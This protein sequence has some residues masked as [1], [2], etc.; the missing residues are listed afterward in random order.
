MKLAYQ[1]VYVL[2][3][4]GTISI[5]C[6]QD[7]GAPAPPAAPTEKAAHAGISILIPT[8]VPLHFGAPSR[9]PTNFTHT[10]EE[11]TA[12]WGQLTKMWSTPGALPFDP[13]VFANKRTTPLVCS[14]GTTAFPALLH[15]FPNRF[16][17][18]PY[19]IRIE[20]DRGQKQIDYYAKRMK[21]VH[22]L[23][24]ELSTLDLKVMDDSD[25]KS[26]VDRES[27]LLLDL[28]PLVERPAKELEQ[29]VAEAIKANEN[30]DR[31]TM[32]DEGESAAA[33]AAMVKRIKA[34]KLKD[35]DE[36]IAQLSKES[37]KLTLAIAAEKRDLEEKTTKLDDLWETERYQ[38]AIGP[39]SEKVKNGWDRKSLDWQPPRPFMTYDYQMNRTNRRASVYDLSESVGEHLSRVTQRCEASRLPNGQ[40]VLQWTV[41]TYEGNA[42][43]PKSKEII[44][45]F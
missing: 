24:N 1:T 13:F 39:I 38:K 9:H 26:T 17:G 11:V 45:C 23:S 36:Q 18:M 7:I 19:Q 35:W 15:A 14:D 12:L 34:A 25:K 44:R 41:F 29:K 32:E 33:V 16:L 4:I 42:T 5:V 30:P 6:A 22:E 27:K 43:E 20:A 8:E 2:A 21:P 10:G 31:G 37:T 40:S 28:R 3:C